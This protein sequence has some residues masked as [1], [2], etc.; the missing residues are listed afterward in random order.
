LVGHGPDLLSCKQLGRLGGG[1]L[2]A[3]FHVLLCRLQSALKVSQLTLKVLYERLKVWGGGRLVLVT[4]R[5]GLALPSP[6]H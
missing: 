3:V 2:P 1:L 4:P 5:P 6:A